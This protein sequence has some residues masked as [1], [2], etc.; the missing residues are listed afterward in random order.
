MACED[1]TKFFGIPLVRTESFQ[2]FAGT[3]AAMIQKDGGE[4]STALRAP[5]QRVQAS[6]PIV[7]DYSFRH[8][9]RLA[10]GRRECERQ[11]ERR[12]DERVLICHSAVPNH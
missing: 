2:F 12:K 8:A 7:D 5:K 10:P 3:A 6:R 9:G 11:N 4:R 1:W